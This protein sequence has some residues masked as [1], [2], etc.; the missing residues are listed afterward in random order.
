MLKTR[1]RESL[2]FKACLEGKTKCVI[3]NTNVTREERARYIGPAKAAGF[4]VAGYFFE[5]IVA[6]ALER[7]RTR[8]EA[9]R[10]PPVAIF[11]SHKHL[12]APSTEEGFDELWRVRLI[13]PEGFLVDAW[14]T[15]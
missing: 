1:P 7:N 4:K 5:S 9:D 11:T 2:L 6:D 13:Q 12:E 10:V 15:E 14:N 3:E 8:P